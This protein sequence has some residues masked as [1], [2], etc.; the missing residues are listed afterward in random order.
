MIQSE[1]AHTAGAA[2]DSAINIVMGIRPI[3]IM[4]DYVL[5]MLAVL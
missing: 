3:I 2:D 5:V 1:L 4:V